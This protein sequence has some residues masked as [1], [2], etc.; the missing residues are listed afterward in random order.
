MYDE[1]LQ[2]GEQEG[3]ELR[4]ARALLRE[5]ADTE[6]QGPELVTLRARGERI[7]DI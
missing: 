7:A 5:L 2:P 6:L 3:D 1:V 4:Y